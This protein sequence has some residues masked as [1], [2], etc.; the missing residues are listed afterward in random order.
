MLVADVKRIRWSSVMKDFRVRFNDAGTG[1]SL[2]ITLPQNWDDQTVVA[3]GVQ[4]KP[5]RDL[6]L[7]LGVNL[8]ENPVPD[9]TLNPLFPAI[10]ERHYTFGAGYRLSA[11]DTIAGAVTYAPEATATN[12][13][14]SITASHSQVS[15]RVNYNRSF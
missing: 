10:V 11:A 3:L 14:T 13:T 8:A 15:L 9:N 7:R 12:P 6:A 1:Q 5:T 4:Y 2:N